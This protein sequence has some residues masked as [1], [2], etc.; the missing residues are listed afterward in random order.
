VIVDIP[1]NI[2]VCKACGFNLEDALATLKEKR[3]VLDLDLQETRK[4][5]TQYQSYSKVCPDCGQENHD[6]TY[7]S[8][9]APHISYGKN[10]MAL[11]AYLGTAHYLSYGRIV[12]TLQTMYKLPIGYFTTFF[13]LFHTQPSTFSTLKQAYKI[14]A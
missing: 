8:F 3:Q 11:V 7:P 1:Y 6:N 13:H 12:Q 2:T 10:I 5:I 4:K 14:V 9:V